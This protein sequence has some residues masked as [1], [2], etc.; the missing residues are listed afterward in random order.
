MLVRYSPVA[1]SLM[2]GVAWAIWHYPLYV[3][4][5][6]ASGP[7]AAAFVINVVALTYLM[8]VL[9]HRTRGSLLLAVLF[10]WTVNVSPNVAAAILSEIRMEPEVVRVYELVALLVVTVVV[11]LATGGRRLGATPAFVV[12]RDLAEESV[13]ADQAG[14]S[15]AEPSRPV[16]DTRR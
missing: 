1:T 7:W 11:V 8:T 14:W 10:H 12:E 13:E 4:S 6:F 3:N 5:V 2:L 9:W 16:P 15:T